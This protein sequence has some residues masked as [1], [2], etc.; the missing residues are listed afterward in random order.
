MRVRF[1]YG[2]GGGGVRGAP[3]RP[4]RATVGAGDGPRVCSA[5]FLRP[6]RLSF[7]FS[8]TST[9]CL[10]SVFWSSER[11]ISS[12][13]HGASVRGAGSGA[14]ADGGRTFP[15]RQRRAE[16]GGRVGH[17]GESLPHES[18]ASGSDGR[19]SAKRAGRGPALGRTGL[20]TGDYD[21]R[22]SLGRPCRWRAAFR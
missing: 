18:D 13:R 22:M 8:T 20:R 11:L 21:G 16:V 3:W 12:M 2:K 15:G 1:G 9:P 19:R 5:S 4:R 6:T 14:G 7:W 10:S 17:P